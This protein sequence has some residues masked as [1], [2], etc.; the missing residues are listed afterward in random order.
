MPGIGGLSIANDLLASSVSL[1]LDR[2]QSSLQ[3]HD[4]Q[5]FGAR[6]VCFRED[7][8]NDHVAAVNLAA[9]KSALRDLDIA[10]GQPAAFAPGS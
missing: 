3:I 10:P 9:S 8:N 6:I 2:N 5:Q 1:N 4:A 7:R